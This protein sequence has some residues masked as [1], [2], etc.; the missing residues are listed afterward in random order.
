VLIN[1]R[2]DRTRLAGC[3]PIWEAVGRES[4][5]LAATGAG[6]IV[7]RPS[8]TE[9]LVRVMVE[10]EDEKELHRIADALASEVER[11]LGIA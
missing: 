4:A 7:L 5:P 10:H 8:G 6:R 2:A 9:P 11:E 1:V 3:N